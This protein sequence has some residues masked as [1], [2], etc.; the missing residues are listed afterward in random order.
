LQLSDS[1]RTLA[2]IWTESDLLVAE[3]LRRRLW[4]GLDPAQLAAAVSVVVY[5]PRRD[6]DGPVQVPRGP[7]ADA[8]DESV[9][10][11]GELAA[12]EAGRGLSLT[13]EPDAGFA[14]PI[15]RWAQ[16]E[17]LARVL[18]SA[19]GSDGELPAGDFVRWARQVVDLL[20]QLAEAAG[21]SAGVKAAA[22]RAM[23]QIT[24]GV[25]AHNLM[26]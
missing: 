5:E 3:C 14:W 11:W 7:V 15:Y 1:G 25:L 16:G 2:R 22:R 26:A 19:A 10:L 20:G 9:K 18:A 12:D 21:V 23:D 13:R 17:P 6:G 4:E 24:R 8:I